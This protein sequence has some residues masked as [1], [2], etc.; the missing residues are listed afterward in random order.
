MLT[1]I[2]L[3]T[4]TAWTFA[5]GDTFIYFVKPAVNNGLIAAVS[6]LSLATARPVVAR[7]AA[8]FYPMSDDVA[9]RPRVQRLFWHL[10]LIWAVV[11]LAMAVVRRE[12]L[13]TSS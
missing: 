7:L 10:T 1:V 6:L 5:S 2:G 12:G 3:T 11:C 4:R 9:K 13:L 8:D